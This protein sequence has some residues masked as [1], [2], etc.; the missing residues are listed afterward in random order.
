MMKKR[1]VIMVSI[2]IVGIYPVQLLSA[3]TIENISILK[4]SS[5][6]KTAVIRTAG[7]SRL[8]VINVGDYIGD[9]IRVI[10]I[11]EGRVVMEKAGKGGT[12][13]ILFNME[14]GKTMLL[15]I[16]NVEPPKSMVTIP[17]NSN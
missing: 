5:K 7:D 17:R 10:D 9:R 11:T 8:A 6:D 14:N 13:T 12:E 15:R 2:I 16:F 3:F 1:I 4:V